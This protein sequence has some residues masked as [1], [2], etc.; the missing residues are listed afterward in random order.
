MA[1]HAQAVLAQGTAPAA[2]NP[3][4]EQFKSLHFRSIG[5]ATMSGR[6]ADLAV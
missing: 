4:A 1:V 6:I 2:A 3:V 5:P